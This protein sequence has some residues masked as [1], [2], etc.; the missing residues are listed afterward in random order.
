MAADDRL[1]EITAQNWAGFVKVVT[2][3]T[4]GI[5]A[6]LALMAIFLI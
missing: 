2:A 1:N 6:V 4:L 5:I 3:S